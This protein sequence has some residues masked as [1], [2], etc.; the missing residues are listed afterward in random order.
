M[1]K[2]LKDFVNQNREGFDTENPPVEVWN[3][4]ENRLGHYDNKPKVLS[5]N[6]YKWLAAAI[7]IAV[8]GTLAVF[9]FKTEIKSIE[10]PEF[11]QADKSD[12]ILINEINP[13]YAKE[14]Y[15]FAKLIELKQ[16]ELK[17]VEK[18]NPDLYKNFIADIY[19]LDSSYKQLKMELPGN[20]NR[21]QLLEAMISNLQVQ[22][23]MLN[24]QL[25]ILQ[26]IKQSKNNLN[27][28]NSKRI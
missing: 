14:L 9:Y 15:H 2:N 20:P 27:E 23:N 8:V 11:V 24:Q 19:S 12:S 16:Q 3:K 26:Q 13:S 25:Q 18:E 4:I 6:R 7:L 1:N 21:E 22:M 10:T 17:Q 28:S 5:M